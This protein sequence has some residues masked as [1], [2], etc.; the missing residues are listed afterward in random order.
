MAR[1]MITVLMPMFK[2]LEKVKAKRIIVLV[3]AGDLEVY[4]VP[5]A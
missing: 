2:A 4:L 5:V 1:T 3:E